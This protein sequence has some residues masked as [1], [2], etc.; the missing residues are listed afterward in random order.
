MNSSSEILR[1]RLLAR[2]RLRHWLGFARTAE[3]GSVRKAA[4]SIG[5]AQPALTHLLADMESLLGSPLFDRHARGM[6]LTRLGQELLP[7]ARRVLGAVDNAAEQAAALQSKSQQV[8]RLGAIGGA[9]SGLL[10][11]ALSMLTK[12]YPAL[13]VQLVETDTAQLD[14]LVAHREIDIALCR[15][16]ELLPQDWRFESLLNDQFVV[17]AGAQHSMAREQRISLAKLRLQTWLAMPTGSAARA[18]FDSLFPRNVPPL[19]QVSSR[20]PLVLWALLKAQPLLA[21]VPASVAR[22]LI[23]SGDLTELDIER[24]LKRL[25]NMAPIGALVPEREPRM[26][27]DA[28]LNVLR[29]VPAAS[30]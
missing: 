2:G 21:L 24:S 29:E 17:V 16:P 7:T 8:V 27:V 30:D 10:L 26:G 11:P 13:M 12:R 5:I 3:L 6:R 19:C 15:A 4:Q 1:Q 28:L 18:M 20:V 23:Q 25:L 14:H 9:V 22:P